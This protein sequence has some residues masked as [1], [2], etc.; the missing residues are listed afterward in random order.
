MIDLSFLSP[1]LQVYVQHLLRT[2][3]EDLWRQI[4]T[5]NA[6][7]Y[8]CGDARNMARDVQ[9]AFYEIAE[10]LGGM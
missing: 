5:D 2:N 1:S 8:I 7:I 3:K 10:E 4:H 6:H 9:T